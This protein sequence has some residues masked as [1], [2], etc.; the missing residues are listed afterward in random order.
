[1]I[2]HP[3]PDRMPPL[4]WLAIY[5]IT[6]LCPVTQLNPNI[7]IGYKKVSCISVSTSVS[8]DLEQFHSTVASE[9]ECSGVFLE[10][11][12]Q[13]SFAPLYTTVKLL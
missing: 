4:P 7:Y 11:T 8:G 5:R 6:A 2:F 13:K 9:K 1:M 12:M 10:K 3:H